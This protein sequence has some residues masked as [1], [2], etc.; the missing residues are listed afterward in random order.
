[1]G[2][3]GVAA[4]LSSSCSTTSVERI[5]AIGKKDRQEVKLKEQ[6]QFA[7]EMNHFLQSVMQKRDPKTPGEEGPRDLRIT[8]AIYRS[9]QEGRPV[10]LKTA[11][12]T[13]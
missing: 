8:Q 12:S 10:L 3:A 7:A 4:N 6:S 1:M 9:D 11:E 13:R 5:Q 2:H